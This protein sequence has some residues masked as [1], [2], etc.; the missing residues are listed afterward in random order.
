VELYADR[1]VEEWPKDED[2]N[3]IMTTKVLDIPSL[4]SELDKI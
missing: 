3:I 2:G 1:L 4:L